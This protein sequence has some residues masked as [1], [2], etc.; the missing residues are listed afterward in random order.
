[1]LDGM[2]KELDVKSVPVRGRSV[3]SAPKTSSHD[4]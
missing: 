2:E 4:G 1:M 3:T